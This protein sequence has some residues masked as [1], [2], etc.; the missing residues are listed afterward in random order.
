MTEIETQGQSP[1]P[2]RVC[3]TAAPICGGIE[4]HCP[5]W[6]NGWIYILQMSHY[7]R[8]GEACLP[9][10]SLYLARELPGG[11]PSDRSKRPLPRR[12]GSGTCS[13]AH[14][15]VAPAA[16]PEPS[17]K[18]ARALA[19]ECKGMARLS[20]PPPGAGA[21]RPGAMA[22][23]GG[24]TP[25]IRAPANQGEWGE[26]VIFATWTVI[27]EQRQVKYVRHSAF[28]RPARHPR[29]SH[30]RLRRLDRR[31]AGCGEAP[32]AG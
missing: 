30:E 14:E 5:C 4:S 32:G 20:R 2:P 11:R 18:K 23:G 31:R 22:G 13:A 16:A 27:Q 21:R 10:R 15:N 28:G 12:D 6:G 3:G 26:C 1:A 19:A 9:C 8:D 7:L 29:P 24:A 25:L 17:L